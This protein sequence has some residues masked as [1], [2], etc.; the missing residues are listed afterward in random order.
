MKRALLA[1]VCAAALRAETGYDAWLRY[2]RGAMPTVTVKRSSALLES[3]RAEL[4]RGARP[5]PEIV[6]GTLA[7]LK[8]TA[9]LKEDGYWLKAEPGKI[10]VTAPNDRGVLYGA[11]ALLRK[12]SLG[13]DL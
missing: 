4:E 3:A 8:M 11:F 12:I 7:D 9:N 10:I 13:S 2:S 1:I 5:G 6:L